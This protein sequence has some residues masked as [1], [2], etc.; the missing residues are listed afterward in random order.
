MDCVVYVKNYKIWLR[1]YLPREMIYFCLWPET[2]A[3]WDQ[4]QGLRWS[5]DKLPF[6][7][8][9][10]LPIH[11]DSYDIRLG[12]L[13]PKHERF[14]RTGPLGGPW[15]PVFLSFTVWSWQKF[16]ISFQV[17][18]ASFRIPFTFSGKMTPNA[19]TIPLCFSLLLGFRNSSLCWQLSKHFLTS[20][21]WG[22]GRG[23]CVCVCFIFLLVFSRQL[24]QII[25]IT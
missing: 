16:W 15:I 24:V 7:R 20:I 4:F 14:T 8:V 25:W 10:L 1:P 5:L 6:R 11:P 21:T 3:F 12:C 22:G 19:R 23:V 9:V 18:A 2:P 13:N 17:L